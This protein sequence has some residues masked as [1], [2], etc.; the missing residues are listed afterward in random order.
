LIGTETCDHDRIFG[1]YELLG[2]IAHGGMGIVYRARQ[3][4]LDRLVALKVLRDGAEATPEDAQRFQNEARL[5]ATLDHPNIIPIYE[6]GAVRGRRFFSMKLVEAPSLAERIHDGSLDGRAA[7]RLMATVARAI[8]H[9]HERGILHRDLKPSN[10]L[11]DGR[12]EPLVA[13]FGL[14]RRVKGDSDLTQ[15]GA[16]V[17]TPAFMAPEQADGRKGAI[18]IATDVHGLGALLYT[19]LA[20]RPPFRGETPLATLDQVREHAPE[21][22][23]TIRHAVDRGLETVCL[24]CLEKD[25]SRRYGTAAEV[26]ADLERWLAGQPI[27]ARR[28]GPAGRAWQHCRRHPRRTA[29]A[30]ALVLLLAT[31]LAGLA[32]GMRARQT[33]A[34]LEHEGG[35]D[36][37]TY[38]RQQCALDVKRAGQL[39]AD[40]HH[41]EALALLDA[42]RPRDGQADLRSFAWHHVHRRCEAGQPPLRGHQ[43]AVYYAT[44]SPDGNTI[45]TAGKDGTVRLWDP[46]S[47]DPRSVLRSRTDEVNW[48]AFPPDGRTLATAGDDQTIK[49]WD[50]ETGRLKS[51][52]TGHHGEV[53]AVLFTPDGR[54]VLSGGR[55]GRIIL[56]DLAAGREADSF[57]LPVGNLQ[58]LAISPGA[59]T[60][61]VAGDRTIVWDLEQRRERWRLDKQSN[62]VAYSH[63]GRILAAA[64]QEGVI[65]ICDARSGRREAWIGA[66]NGCIES[67]AFAPDDRHLAS[68]IDRGILRLWDRTTGTIEMLPT[69]QDRPWCVA[70]SPDGR[71]IVTS[72]AD[73]DV[74]LWRT[75]RDLGSI[76]P[77]LP[78]RR[79]GSPPVLRSAMAFARDG[80]TLALLDVEG[81]VWS[82]DI[83]R[84]R[85]VPRRLCATE[86][87]IRTAVF[88]DDAILLIAGLDGGSMTVWDLDSGDPGRERPGHSAC[89]SLAISGDRRWIAEASLGRGIALHE[90]SGG[91]P[92]LL[93]E[94]AE[95]LL[96]SPTGQNLAG[97]WHDWKTPRFWDLSSGQSREGRGSGHS[98]SIS[99]GAFSHD[100]AILATGGVD[101]SIILWD[102]RSFDRIG[103][104]YSV[105]GVRSLAFSPDG[106]TLASGDWDRMVRL[107]D[108]ASGTE[109]AVLEGHTAGVVLLRFSP[110]GLT[111]ASCAD[112]GGGR[113]EILLWPATP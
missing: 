55:D 97:W 24:K 54:R 1:D 110:D 104:M 106:L 103:R 21:P 23:S 46:R 43:G 111:L 113:G 84:G 66:A 102:T 4:S 72:S 68:V 61:A 15:S 101:G 11:I 10:I 63:D 44:F 59:E 73:G 8:Q 108:V 27:A 37:L 51:T 52:L 20:G 49:L 26:A 50:A 77:S 89:S 80:R 82:Y 105:S 45:A 18:G 109:L 112:L 56:W 86:K 87:A 107:W 58:C 41:G 34:Q 93:V 70:Y 30:F 60:L 13:D 19:L 40:N 67:I 78:S 7:A 74:R 16:I 94:N 65:A 90:R 62:S 22:P 42:Y 57:V 31:S 17:G 85:A 98:A 2:K 91:P 35:R 28:V 3:L 47:G 69:R 9:A 12:G 95:G 38:R 33:V 81:T 48:V 39:L 100:G 29:L 92:R 53:V 76:A 99:A 32:L 25:P 6:V 71:A 83:H 36:R 79:D 96:F 14:A 5:V 64:G 88:S 75:D